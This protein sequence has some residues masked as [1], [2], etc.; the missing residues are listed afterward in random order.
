MKHRIHKVITTNSADSYMKQLG[1]QSS[2]FHIMSA[3][4]TPIERV[5]C[6]LQ[7]SQHAI[8]QWNTSEVHNYVDDSENVQ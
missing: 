4:F 8:E 7:Y 3:K 1:V 6:H 2:A 5:Q